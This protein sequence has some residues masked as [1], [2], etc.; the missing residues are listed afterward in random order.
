ML[1]G[2]TSLGAAAQAEKITR[3]ESEKIEMQLKIR[4]LFKCECLLIELQAWW[5]ESL[6]YFKSPLLAPFPKISLAPRRQ[7]DA[8]TDMG[9]ADALRPPDAD[10]GANALDITVP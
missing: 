10:G 6:C 5:G 4:D 7:H 2:S 1:D 8:K 3:V 9:A